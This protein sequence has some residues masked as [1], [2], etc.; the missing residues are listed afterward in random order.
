MSDSDRPK[1]SIV[2]PSLN[3]GRFLQ[4]CIDSIRQQNWPGVE[5]FIIDGGSTDETLDVIHKNAEWITG[6]VSEPDRGAADAINKGFKKC[7][8]DIVAWLNADDFYL[9]DAFEQIAKAYSESPEAGFWFGNGIRAFING[10]KKS[11]FNDNEIVYDHSALVRGLDYILQPSAFINPVH[12]EA[13][14]YLN[15]NLK[16]TFDWDLWIRLALSAPPFPVNAQLSASREWGET[17]TATGGFRRAEE[18]RQLAEGHSGQPMTPGALLYWL[19]NMTAYVKTSKSGFSDESFQALNKLWSVV[20]ADFQAMNVDAMGSP[21][22]RVGMSVNMSGTL[23]GNSPTLDPEKIVIGVDLF[24]LFAGVSGG[25]IPWVK[26]VLQEFVKMYPQDRFLMF[27]RPGEPPF[28]IEGKNVEYFPLDDHPGVFYERLSIVC[29][30]NAV[31]ALIRTYPQEQHPE[32]PFQ[33]QIFV[34]PDIQHEVFPEFF[35]QP[36]LAARRRGFTYALSCGGAVAT[37]TEHSKQTLLTE[38][39][40]MCDDIFLMPAALP[41]EL[42]YP[43][44][45]DKLPEQA[46]DF[47]QFFFM[48]ANLWP[49]KNHERL[50]KAFKLALPDL[51]GNTGLVLSGNPEGLKDLI[52]GYEDLPIRHVGFVPHDQ[53]AALFKGATALVYFSLFEGFGMPLLEAFHHGTPVLCSASSC[54]P[55]VGGDAVLVCDPLDVDAMAQLMRRIATETEVREGLSQLAQKRCAAYNWKKPADAL[56]QALI[57]VAQNDA[58]FKERQPLVSIV[59]PTRNHAQ[60]IRESIDSIL[61]QTYPNIELLVLDGCSTDGTVEI[62]KSYGEQIRWISEPDNGQTDAI[63]KGLAQLG[64][65]IQ[66]YLNSDDIL[67]PDAVEK[68]ISHFN[69]HPACD[70]LYGRAD[71]IDIAGNVTGEYA[72]DDYSFDRLMLDNCICQPATFWRRRIYQKIGPFD[73]TMQTA[74]DY[75]YWLRMASLG[76]IIEYTHEKLA[77]SRLHEDAKTLSMRGK[78]FEEIFEICNRHGGY[79]SLNYHVG[80]WSYR[81]YESWSGGARLRKV[82]PGMHRVLGLGD[83]STQILKIARDSRRRAHVSRTMFNV[84]DRRSTTAGRVLRSTWHRSQTVRRW[85]TS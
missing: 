78:I 2:T 28:R 41:E 62:L 75:E 26:G 11:R 35:P 21:M 83:F 56:R 57:R 29:S 15:T 58:V 1:F 13:V 6:Y 43:A 19:D 4:D 12:L 31:N 48:P 65:D 49:H 55:E 10:K 73:E 38:G 60:F 50:F 44:D 52:T 42:E 16:W 40:A 17:L 76:G 14:G 27:H 70:M 46:R 82:M 37:L 51:P 32:F 34:I 18:I 61:D 23:I 63:N 69:E 22:P 45:M 39:H 67:L 85:F 53:M 30:Q 7:H 68:A 66:A 81:L 80:F 64:G 47:D 9:P 8:G 71:Y 79:V 72:T 5:H 33:R 74:M 24:P 84:I 25:I 3:Q 54:L 59:M 77:Q 36:T 20:Q